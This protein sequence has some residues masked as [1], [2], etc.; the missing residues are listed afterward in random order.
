VRGKEQISRG[1][2][3]IAQAKIAQK[4]VE[5]RMDANLPGSPYGD[6]MQTQQATAVAR[7]G[8]LSA[9]R[10]YNQAQLRLFLLTGAGAHE[11]PGV[12]SCATKAGKPE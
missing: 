3:A 10:G 11:L 2:E 4:L 9:V 8:Y 1:E 7:V 5:E 6:V 12:N